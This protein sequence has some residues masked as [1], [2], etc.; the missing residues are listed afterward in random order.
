MT[1]FRRRGV[2]ETVGYLDE[3]EHLCMDYEYWLRIGSHYTPISLP[4]DIANFRLYQTSK[5][6]SSFVQQFQDELRIATTYAA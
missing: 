3:H 4:H 2:M 1:V 6:G 5:S